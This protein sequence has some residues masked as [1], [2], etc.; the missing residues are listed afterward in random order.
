MITLADKL[1]NMRITKRTFNEKGTDMWRGVHQTDHNLQG[2]YYKSI[3]GCVSELKDTAAYKE[4]S[5]LCDY[6]F[7][8]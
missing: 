6:V 8:E 3:L 2:W 5:E 1:S 7:G 4:Y